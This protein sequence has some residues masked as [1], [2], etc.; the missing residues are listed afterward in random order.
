MCSERTHA[1]TNGGHVSR[2]VEE[3]ARSRH[4]LSQLRA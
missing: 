3:E 4:Y 2:P 1:Q